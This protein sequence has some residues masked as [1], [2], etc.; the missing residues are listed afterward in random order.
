MKPH[1]AKGNCLKHDIA[2][3][4]QFAPRVPRLMPGR[5]CSASALAVQA[6]GLDPQRIRAKHRPVALIVKCIESQLY[7][8][9]V[10][11]ILPAAQVGPDFS[12]FLVKTNANDV[13][14]IVVMPHIHISP[15]SR[16]RP[17]NRMQGDKIA[18]SNHIGALR[19]HRFEL[20]KLGWSSDKWDVD[21]FG[22]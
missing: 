4:R 6:I 14:A 20:L 12:R 9:I 21:D 3:P 19:A 1:A 7:V 10:E 22:K 8:I 16:R 13:K 15:L 11:N 2:L 5:I 18:H 17:I